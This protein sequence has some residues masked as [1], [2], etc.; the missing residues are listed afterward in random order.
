MLLLIDLFQYDADC[1]WWLDG[2]VWARR[3]GYDEELVLRVK[4]ELSSGAGAGADDSLNF[5]N[6]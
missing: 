2:L 6:R 4:N 3:Q 5:C 1:P